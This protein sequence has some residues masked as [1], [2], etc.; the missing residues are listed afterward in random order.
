LLGCYENFPEAVHGIAQFSHFL[1]SSVLQ[2]TILQTFHRLNH[3]SHNVGEVTPLAPS[4]CEAS[5]EFGLAEGSAFNYLDRDEADRALK[6]VS[7]K[8][9]ETL[10]FF[11]AIRYRAID[12]EKRSR[13]KFDYYLLRFTFERGNAEMRV[14]H[15]RGPRRVSPEELLVFLVKDINKGLSRNRARPLTVK[16]MRA[17]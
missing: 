16:N 5:F 1:S 10:D 14:F 15:E 2:Q 12:K 13:L 7:E 6:T 8:A 11:C 17:L 4:E 9:L 3:E